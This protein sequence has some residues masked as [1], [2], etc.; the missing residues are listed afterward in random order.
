[1]KLKELKKIKGGD[2]ADD[3]ILFNLLSA[4]HCL[5]CHRQ[6]FSKRTIAEENHSKNIS[7]KYFICFWGS[8]SLK[9]VIG[10]LWS[11]IF[12]D[13]KESIKKCNT[14]TLHEHDTKYLFLNMRLHT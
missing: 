2:E 11:F 12:K 4:G 1:M 3:F 14:K 5:D 13:L 6:E 7:I 8:V 10:Y 9:R